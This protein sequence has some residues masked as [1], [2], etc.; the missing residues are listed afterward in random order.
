MKSETPRECAERII[1]NAFE[2]Y[3]ATG[4]HAPYRGMG[5]AITA[6]L[7]ERERER[8]NALIAGQCVMEQRDRLK[9]LLAEAVEILESTSIEHLSTRQICKA[10]EFTGRDEVMAATSSHTLTTKEKL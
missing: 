7:E 6:A 2:Y 10:C 1:R 5:D 4:K 8:D 9:A 3:R